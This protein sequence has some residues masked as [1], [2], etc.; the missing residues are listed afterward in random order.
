MEKKKGNRRKI[1]I[2]IINELIKLANRID[3]NKS[4]QILETYLKTPLSTL[5]PPSSTIGYFISTAITATAFK[6]FH[7]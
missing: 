1:F 4:G 5:V 3:Y 7:I 2:Y 6:F